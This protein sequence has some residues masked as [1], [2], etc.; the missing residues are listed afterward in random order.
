MKTSNTSEWEKSFDEKFVVFLGPDEH[1]I[2]ACKESDGGLDFWNDYKLKSF[3]SNLLSKQK[4][5]IVGE[6]EGLDYI[7]NYI[8][9]E[10]W[11]GTDGEESYDLAKKDIITLITIQHE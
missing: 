3:I 4:Q 6:I 8:G 10:H 7:R 2:V 9:T 5:E 11:F 1:H